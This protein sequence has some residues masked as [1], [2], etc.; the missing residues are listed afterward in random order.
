MIR[1]EISHWLDHWMDG[2]WLVQVE[3]WP[4]SALSIPRI[5]AHRGFCKEGEIENT[6]SAFR[7]ARK[8]GA[9]MVETDVRLTRDQVPVLFHDDNLQ[10]LAGVP[11]PVRLLT[12]SELRSKVSVTT[13]QELLIDTE[14]PRL[15]N[16]ELKSKS[17]LD[18]PLE[19]KVADVVKQTRAGSRVLFSSFNPF[20]LYRIG[21]YLPDVPR[22]LLVTPEDDPDNSLFLRK[23]LLAPLFSFH[24]LHLDQRMVTEASMK[25]W[26]RKKIP[27][28]VWTV[29]GKENISRF[30]QMGCL[31]VISDDWNSV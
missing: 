9:L 1:A 18:D 25:V 21:L 14:S 30:L 15:V 11:D 7:Q 22:A 31:S 29:N 8:Q 20:S 13:L 5:Q 3:K 2:R 26:R 16:I 4:R 27:V 19:R 6:L 23:M 28:S 24:L 17:V 12:L 10:R